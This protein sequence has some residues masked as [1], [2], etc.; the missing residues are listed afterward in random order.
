MGYGLRIENKDKED[1][2]RR[3]LQHSPASTRHRYSLESYMVSHVVVFFTFTDRASIIPSNIRGCQSGTWSAGQ[4]NIGGTSK[5]LQ[6]E[7]LTKP[8]QKQDKNAKQKE[9]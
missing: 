8:K 1:P 9:Q 6:R 5:K 3:Y 2:D 7:H 4:E